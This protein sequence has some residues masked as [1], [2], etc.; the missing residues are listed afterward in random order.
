MERL[1]EYSAKYKADPKRWDFVTTPLIDIT[2]IGTVRPAI[3]ARQSKRAHQ[4]QCPNGRRGCQRHHPMG[5]AGHRFQ[6]R[7]ARRADGQGCP[8][9]SSQVSPGPGRYGFG[10]GA[11]TGG[12]LVTGAVGAGRFSLVRIR[13]AYRGGNPPPGPPPCRERERKSGQSAPSSTRP[14]V[15]RSAMRNTARPGAPSG[16]DRPHGRRCRLLDSGSAG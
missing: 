6:A 12:A 8:C 16:A 3:L 13:A 11:T 4:S 7:R 15:A 2:A 1:K 9:S 14:A 5:H 10:C